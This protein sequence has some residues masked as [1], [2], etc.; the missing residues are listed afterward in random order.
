GHPRSRRALSLGSTG[1]HRSA[2]GPDSENH[3][4]GADCDRTDRLYR[5]SLRATRSRLAVIVGELA[6]LHVD[7]FCWRDVRRSPTDYDRALVA[8]DHSVP[9]GIRRVPSGRFRVAADH[10]LLRQAPRFLVVE[11]R[12]GN[13]REGRLFESALL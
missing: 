9:G 1:R 13:P 7:L 11:S 10:Y 5:R 8:A 6:L 2:D 12:P 4:A 3:F